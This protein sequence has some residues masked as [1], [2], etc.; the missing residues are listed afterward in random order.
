MEPRSIS[1]QKAQRLLDT[2]DSPYDLKQLR[3]DQLP[4]LAEEMRERILEVV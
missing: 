3:R 4:K 2:I 1:T